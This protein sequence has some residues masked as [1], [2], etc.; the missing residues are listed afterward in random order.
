M[1]QAK[2]IIIVVAVLVI[3]GIIAGL[4]IQSYVASTSPIYNDTSVSGHINQSLKYEVSAV[5]FASVDNVTQH[6]FNGVVNP[7]GVPA[8]MEGGSSYLITLQNGDA[9]RAW[10]FGYYLD[11]S[12]APPCMLGTIT[13]SN[14][15]QESYNINLDASSC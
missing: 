13:L 1:V 12:S 4:A 7:Y 11:G 3:G 5:Y 8:R 15:H 9:Y 14:L 2:G 6:T 10:A